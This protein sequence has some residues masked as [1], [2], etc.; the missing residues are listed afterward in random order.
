VHLARP[1]AHRGF[2]AGKFI[3]KFGFYVL[4][5]REKIPSGAA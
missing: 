2:N 4:E 1:Q 3:S 5:S